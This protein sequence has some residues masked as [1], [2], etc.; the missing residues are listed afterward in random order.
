MKIGAEHAGS[1]T[2]TRIAAGRWQTEGHVRPDE[3]Q[4][5]RPPL[6]QLGLQEGRRGLEQAV[7]LSQFPTFFPRFDT[8]NLPSAGELTSEELEREIGR[9][10]V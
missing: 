8:N 9:A 4:G 5:C 6:Q 3:N 2:L 7:H 1:D 10:H